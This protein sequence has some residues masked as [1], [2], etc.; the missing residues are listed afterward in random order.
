[1]WVE[2]THT[3]ETKDVSSNLVDKEPGHTWALITIYEWV[4]RDFQPKYNIAERQTEK[5]EFLRTSGRWK[6]CQLNLKDYFFC[7]KNKTR[8]RY[9]FLQK[10][11]I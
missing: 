4:P 1:M 2:K 8:K 3:T 9:D 7:M 5:S 6:L 11:P 10:L